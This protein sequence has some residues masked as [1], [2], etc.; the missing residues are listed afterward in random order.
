M[1][2]PSASCASIPQQLSASV[3]RS[4][5]LTSPV[6]AISWRVSK[7]FVWFFFI[8]SPFNVGIVTSNKIKTRH[9]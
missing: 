2:L 7:M 6:Q 3:E 4:T 1:T 8:A 5:N 9:N